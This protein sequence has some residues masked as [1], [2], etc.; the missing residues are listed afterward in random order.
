MTIPE[1][2]KTQMIE[3]LGESVEAFDYGWTIRRC[4][5][6]GDPVAGGPTACRQ[7]T[8]DPPASATI[9]EDRKVQSESR[10][11]TSR[12][13]A[14]ACV[15]E[16]AG[17]ELLALEINMTTGRARIELVGA[18]KYVTFDADP[19]GRASLTIEN[20]LKETVAVG[21]R[22]DRARV[23]RTKME[24]VHRERFEGTRSGLRGLCYY[25]ADNAPYAGFLTRGDVRG[26]ISALLDGAT[27][28]L[29]TGSGQ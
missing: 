28:R 20:R 13:N 11:D 4:R 1:P 29:T 22:G 24:F 26:A 16:R 5:H 23:E 12:A 18:H 17:W 2:T 19:I 21:R 9:R 14:L 8:G 27:H 6:C 15:L 3:A 7:C 25:L 10:L